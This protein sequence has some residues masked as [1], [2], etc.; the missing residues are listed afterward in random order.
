MLRFGIQTREALLAASEKRGRIAPAIAFP[1]VAE[2]KGSL[3]ER[4]E[5][6]L[7]YLYRAIPAG[8][9]IKLTWRERLRGL[10]D[11]LLAEI[12]R[13]YAKDAPLGVHDI[14]VS[15]GITSVALFARLTEAGRAVTYLASDFYDAL[16]VVA[17]PGARWRVVFDAEG[18]PIQIVGRR[19]VL[20]SAGERKRFP[21][22]RL[23]HA[24]AERNVVPKA[25]A[26]LAEGG[27]ERIALF[28]PD[29]L[30]LAAGDPHFRLAREDVFHPP[31]GPF[32]VVKV[33]SLLSRH[34]FPP[35]IARRAIA[36][37]AA[38]VREGGLLVLGRSQGLTDRLDGTL[39]A[40][41]GGR[42]VALADL[43]DGYDY[44]DLVTAL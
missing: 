18:K 30:A 12:E 25:R 19:F 32:D 22:N 20:E 35:E 43:H 7:A 42:L 44:R 23:V 1:L 40:K 27:A 33:L 37:V 13:R 26:L 31:P 34:R 38:T 11:L 9:S 29:A 10:D 6:A 14:A 41:E 2:F 3:S 8:P 39:F 4:E 28:H 16:Q 5:N 36:A 24:W 15:N 21:V 17:L